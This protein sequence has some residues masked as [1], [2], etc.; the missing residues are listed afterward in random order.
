[1]NKNVYML[2]LLI[3]TSHLVTTDC[4]AKTRLKKIKS[5]FSNY[6]LEK[7]EQRELPTL[8][9]D[10][11]SID[12]INGPITIKTGW[13]KNF[14]S[15]KT[16]KR[17]KKQEDLNNIEVVD[18]TTDNHIAI[19][20]KYINPKLVGSVEYELIVPA[21]LNLTLT[22]SEDGQAS[23]KDVHGTINIV[24]NDAILVTNN[25][26]L[27]SA[28][29]RKKGT[30]TVI[31]AAG[32][33]DA[34]S[35]YG[36]IQGDNIANSFSAHSTTGKVTIAYKTLPP[37]SSIDLKTSGNI[38]LALP[39]DTNAKI[40]GYTAHGTLISDHYITLKPYATQLNSSAW[41]KF[42]KE[43]DGILG[44]GEATIALHS[45]KGNVKISE[46]KAT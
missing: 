37:T 17:A 23:V 3:I 43:V 46:I 35:H 10:S 31:N 13:K 39:T 28:K 19:A 16:T 15:L 1:M 14:L 41:N 18:L 29:T 7:V 22:I 40:H 26:Q 30:I 11:I 27:V 42:K 4:T 2:L 5:F 34:Q 6:K 44:T 20:T 9:I 45:T 36:N 33:V 25:K 12:N 21:S 38:C 32:P 8:L 24:T